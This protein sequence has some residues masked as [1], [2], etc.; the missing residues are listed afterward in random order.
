M[1]KLLL[2]AVAIVLA[3][4]GVFFI[5]CGLLQDDTIDR[6][7][8]LVYKVGCRPAYSS[9]VL[10]G[11]VMVPIYHSAQYYISVVN[12]DDQT[13]CVYLNKTDWEKYKRGDEYLIKNGNQVEQY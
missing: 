12:D 7:S 13:F 2:T 6:S 10:A 11:K 4:I 1:T 3:A 9:F 8:G 5:V